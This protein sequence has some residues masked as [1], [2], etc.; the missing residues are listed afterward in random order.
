MKG[1]DRSLVRDYRSCKSKEYVEDFKNWDLDLYI[2][3]IN[4]LDKKYEEFQSK[5]LNIINKHAPLKVKTKRQR[6]Q[7]LKPWIMNG[8]LKSIHNK[9]KL[10]K[11]YL[12][13]KDNFWYQR[14]KKH[15]NMLNQVIRVS[16][17]QSRLSYF[18]KLKHDY[19]QIWRGIN[20]LL[21]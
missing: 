4:A 10:Y 17:R 6:K 19:K 21:R 20:N 15:R 8:I 13:T 3:D 1:K 2:N 16:K 11:K 18:E 12:K 5:V 9:N 14:Y 7:L